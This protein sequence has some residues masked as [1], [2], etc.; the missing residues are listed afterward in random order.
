MK[1]P[2]LSAEVDVRPFRVRFGAETWHVLTG[3]EQRIEDMIAVAT[4]A[5]LRH[6][7]SRRA[8]GTAQVE[9]YATAGQI[10]RLEEVC[11]LL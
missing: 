3:S 7:W 11:P 1:V 9:V 2:V 10:R 4:V 5:G 6:R 8:D